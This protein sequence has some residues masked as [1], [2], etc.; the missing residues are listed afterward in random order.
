[1]SFA[2]SPTFTR[3]HEFPASIWANI[4]IPA[5]ECLFTQKTHKYVVLPQHKDVWMERYV[6]TRWMIRKSFSVGYMIRVSEILKWSVLP[7]PH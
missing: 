4:W 1:M 5:P 3:K 6:T 7:S 2:E